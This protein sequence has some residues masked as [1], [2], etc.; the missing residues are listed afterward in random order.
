MTVVT[1]DW[2]DDGCSGNGELVLCQMI[3][4]EKGQIMLIMVSNTHTMTLGRRENKISQIAGTSFSLKKLTLFFVILTK[5][6]SDINGPDDTSNCCLA[7]DVL[8][9]WV[10]G[11]YGPHYIHFKST[12]AYV[13]IHCPISQHYHP[14]EADTP[15]FIYDSNIL[16]I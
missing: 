10:Q 3:I 13:L 15:L 5:P 4:K 1:Y 6:W 9:C 2:S 8:C 12:K 11:G 14:L 7:S 16:K